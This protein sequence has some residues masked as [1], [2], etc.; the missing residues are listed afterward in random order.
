TRARAAGAAA[1]SDSAAPRWHWLE[2][3]GIPLLLFVCFVRFDMARNGFAPWAIL[4]EEGEMMAWVNTVLRGGVLSRDVYCLYGP[5]SIYP[6]ALLF[7][8]FHPSIWIWRVWIY[9]LNVPALFAVYALLR[10]LTRRRLSA[11][12]GMLA[13]GLLCTS[14]TPAMS[15]SV[16]RVALGLGAIAAL[17]AFLRSGRARWLALS[18]LALG[19]ALFY[20][21][22]VGVS[23]AL[24]VVAALAVA[25]WSARARDRLVAFGALV[26]GAAL[27]V[28][29]L[30]ALFAA[31]GALGETLDNL[32]VFP[33]VR[34]LG[35]AAY[36]FPSFDRGVA[37]F[38]S[39][40]PP[41]VARL[42]AL[43]Y[44]GPVALAVA[45]VV[46]AL[47]ALRGPLAG[48]DIA[49]G[50]VLIFGALLFQSGLSRPDSPHLLFCLPPA[51]VLLACFMEE[52]ALA[53]G[54]RGAHA[55]PRAAAG[56]FV[57]FWL[58]ALGTIGPIWTGS[59]G[60][61]FHQAALTLTGR[62]AVRDVPGFRAF[63]IPRARG[64]CAPE[65]WVAD[66]E[67]VV[68][69]LDART[70][71]DQPV[72]VFPN[73]VMINFLADRP[74]ANSFPLDIWAITTDQRRQLV[75]EVERSRPP[76]A[77]FYVD[78]FLV[79]EIPNRVALPEPFAYLQERYVPDRTIGRWIVERRRE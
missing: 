49:L 47:R 28:I 50:A 42:T 66:V 20:S 7:K 31:Q 34:M 56:A 6:V 11:F 63:E 15:W 26:G 2:W 51:L 53:L 45:A 71:R 18:G 68:R 61:C 59:L 58:L 3:A 13:V 60:D 78:A 48:R 73:E 79:D 25:T 75:A 22:E 4:G 41:E 5:L 16:S 70:R 44:F 52:A 24:G 8:L 23:A 76:F 27:V 43:A 55:A 64:T 30:L 9:S 12:L 69:D 32:F 36:A 19:V 35:Y 65:G 77:V 21:Q 29:P 74:L 33:R 62:F 1:A 40:A 46:L 17:R 37:L 54:A 39:G 14:Q 72:W 57:A 67:S 38:L 10:G